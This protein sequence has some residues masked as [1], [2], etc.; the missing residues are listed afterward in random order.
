MGGRAAATGRVIRLDV[1]GRRM[2]AVYDGRWRLF[3]VGSEGKRRPSDLVIPDFVA[4][5]EIEQYLF[6]L[7]HESAHPRHPRIVRL[8]DEP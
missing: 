1:F 4:P 7:L 6:D 5:D 3:E 8:P 2:D